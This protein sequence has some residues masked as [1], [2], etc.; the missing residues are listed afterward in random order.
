LPLGQRLARETNT[1][2]KREE[3]DARKTEKRGNRFE[4]QEAAGHS[5][6]MYFK[7]QLLAQ[8]AD[9]HHVPLHLHL[10]SHSH[11]SQ[12]V[13]SNQNQEHRTRNAEQRGTRNRPNAER[14]TGGTR[15]RRNAEPAERGFCVLLIYIVPIYKG[16][17]GKKKKKVTQV[18]KYFFWELR[19]AE[20]IFA[21][22]F[23]I[24]FLNSP[25]YETPKNAIK[26]NRA[27]QPWVKKKKTEGKKAA[28]FV[29]SPDG[30][31]RKKVFFVFFEL[32]LLRNAPKTPLKKIDK[33]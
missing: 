1:R 28:F 6:L 32:P 29:M 9:A 8:V 4:L 16:R 24:A 10:A 30:F 2:E 5:G 13:A 20:E 3:R 14:G 22:F 11:L 15:N 25:C 7:T 19:Q 26:K 33:K 27:K 21:R 17:R 18:S 12:L 23:F 31:F